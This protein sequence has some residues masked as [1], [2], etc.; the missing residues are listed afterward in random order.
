MAKIVINYAA[1]MARYLAEK[2]ETFRY[3]PV[4]IVDIGARWG[5]N[6]EWE[7]FG[8][9]LRVYCFEPDQKECD[10]LN[11][12]AAD[13]VTYVPCA[14]GRAK[15]EATL[16]E[17]RLSASSGL[18]KTNMDYFSRLIN[19]DNGVTVAEHPIRVQTLS[20]A[21]ETFGVTSVDFLKL[22]VEGAEL[23][24]LM[25]AETYLNNGLLLGILSE[26]RFHEEI[27]GCPIFWQLDQY[28]HRFGFRLYDLQFHHQSRR[29]LP[30]PSL[31]D[32]RLPDGK[33]FFAY[34][35]HG[36]IMD[37][38]A[39]YFRDPLI[40]ANEDRRARMTAP[41]LLKM[42]A[43]LE[44][45]SLNDCAAE[46]ILEHE[47]RLKSY[48]DIDV[49][50]DH[51]TPD[52]NG[53]KLNHNEYLQRYFDERGGI[54]ASPE[55]LRSAGQAEFQRIYLAIRRRLIRLLRGFTRPLR[56]WGKR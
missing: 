17:A 14:I 36:Q 5:F 2:T 10:R 29:A 54:F 38:D 49:L 13:N 46:L 1:P 23:D 3:D 26:I 7:V 30:Y 25:G 42:A 8:K 15:G 22:D 37:G 52:A 12:S 35:T 32:Y 4:I 31:A 41:Q 28:V 40:S 48:V 45:Y 50:L 19:R 20:D 47:S 21:L 56:H 11:A 55:A 18:Y 9:N 24:I 53:G 27:N 43:F 51:L 34:T 39:L 33:R 44:I 16:F 6:A